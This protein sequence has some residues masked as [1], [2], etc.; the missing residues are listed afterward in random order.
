VT[1][2]HVRYVFY[3][4][5]YLIHYI[6]LISN[7]LTSQSTSQHT[8]TLVIYYRGFEWHP[9]TWIWCAKRLCQTHEIS[10]GRVSC[11]TLGQ[12]YSIPSLRRSYWHHTYTIGCLIKK[13]SFL[14]VTH[15][16]I[17][18]G[19]H[20]NYTS[21]RAGKQKTP[22]YRRMYLTFAGIGYWLQ[23]LHSLRPVPD[24][25]PSTDRISKHVAGCSQ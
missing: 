21:S 23:K 20:W 6:S 9:P 1:A 3:Y 2:H 7:E 10:V 18:R 24:A 11:I 22:S 5:I 25:R 8:S 15:Q 16:Y 19:M 13:I 4:C 14:P 17:Q 12:M